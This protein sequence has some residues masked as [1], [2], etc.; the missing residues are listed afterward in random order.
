MKRLMRVMSLIVIGLL[1]YSLFLPSHSWQH[2]L[3]FGIGALMCFYFAWQWHIREREY[4]WVCIAT[5]MWF[6]T[7]V[8]ND[9]TGYS[10]PTDATAVIFM[11]TLLIYLFRVNRP[12]QSS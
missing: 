1:I 6:T 8:V 3:A 4:L 10:W 11:V 9:L 12:V 7:I 2:S 5:G